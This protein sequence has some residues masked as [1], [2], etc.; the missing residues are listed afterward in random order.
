M[1]RHFIHS[2]EQPIGIVAGNAAVQDVS[3]PEELTPV[4]PLRNTVSKKKQLVYAPLAA[5]GNMLYG[6]RTGNCD[7]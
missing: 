4:A 5:G 6:C 7:R 1:P 2:G 3:L